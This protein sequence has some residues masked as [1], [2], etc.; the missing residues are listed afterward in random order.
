MDSP[1][2]ESQTEHP[3]FHTKSPGS[4][5][6]FYSQG[7]P[8]RSPDW[9]RKVS[10]TKYLTFHT[11]VPGRP[12]SFPHHESRIEAAFHTKDPKQNPPTFHTKS[13]GSEPGLSKPRLPD[14]SRARGRGTHFRTSRPAIQREGKC[15]EG[16]RVDK[17]IAKPSLN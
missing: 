3:A 13:P 10:K 4:K 9:P 1:N 8:G 11:E 6:G 16:P 17:N 2:Q 14:R 12:S 15:I 7:V 5:P